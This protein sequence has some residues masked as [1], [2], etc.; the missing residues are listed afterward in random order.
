MTAKTPVFVD[1]NILIQLHV[2]T[3]IKHIQIKNAFQK[4]L[5][6]GYEI[7]ISRQVMREYT[8]V[9]TR[10]QPY[11]Q[12]LPIHELAIQLRAFEKQY[13]IADETLAVTTQLCYLMDN[14]LF[15]GK[16]VHDAN[17]VATMQAYGISTIFTLN[18]VDFNRFQSLITIITLDQL[19]K[20]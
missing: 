16:Q 1:T 19:E 3:A 11:A 14:F 6:S 10:P 17:I 13:Q 5:N 15:A 20:M 12:P 18:D 4:L 8:S 7:W 9:L 2:I